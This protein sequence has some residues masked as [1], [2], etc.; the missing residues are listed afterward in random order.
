MESRQ[1][2]LVRLQ[3][4]KANKFDKLGRTA[5]KERERQREMGER[6]KRE[7][8]IFYGLENCLHFVF[9]CIR[10][11]HT[12]TFCIAATWH[13]IVQTTM[14]T[15]DN[16]CFA[17]CTWCNQIP[18]ERFDLLVAFVDGQAEQQLK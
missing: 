8:Q 16:V 17:R 10:K 9:I 5:H 6:R 4:T 15:A 2:E 3:L 11:S 12:L 1:H 14:I 18:N 7:E 13:Q